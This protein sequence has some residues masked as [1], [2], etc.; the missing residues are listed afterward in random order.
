MTYIPKHSSNQCSKKYRL[1]MIMIHKLVEL[2][3][4]KIHY[5]PSKEVVKNVSGCAQPFCW[6]SSRL[7][8]KTHQSWGIISNTWNQINGISFSQA[9]TGE[10]CLAERQIRSNKWNKWITTGDGCCHCLALHACLLAASIWLS[11]SCFVRSCEK[12]ARS[13]QVKKNSSWAISMT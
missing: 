3:L 13:S 9:D 12:W 5:T 6:Q 2:V 10:H 8:P 4:W 7:D 1:C 11:L